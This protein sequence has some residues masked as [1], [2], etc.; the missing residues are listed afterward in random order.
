MIY[1]E[2]E[3]P[4]IGSN[5]LHG[6]IPFWGGIQ[7]F[8]PAPCDREATLLQKTTHKLGLYKQLGKIIKEATTIQKPSF[9]FLSFICNFVAE[10]F[11]AGNHSCQIILGL[12][13]MCGSLTDVKKRNVTRQKKRVSGI[14]Y[15]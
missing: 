12:Q 10:S 15:Q 14:I 4:R 6:M 8:V 3:K 7:S 9:T 5:Q 13:R 1:E 2:T 11:P